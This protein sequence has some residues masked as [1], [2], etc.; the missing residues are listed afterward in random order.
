MK[1]IGKYLILL[2]AAVAASPSC[3]REIS[4]VEPGT[5]PVLSV[6]PTL[7]RGDEASLATK[8]KDDTV[9]TI[10][11]NDQVVARD[12]LR[13]NF[14]GSLDIFVKKQADAP[15]TAW[16]KE[17]H[18]NAGDS[19]V[20]IDPDKYD[21]ES[22]LDQAKQA[23]AS[24]WAE[25]GYEPDTPYDIYV[26]ANNP[27]TASGSAPA[28]LTALQALTTNTTDVYRYYLT[29]TPSQ[30]DRIYWTNCMYSEKKNFLMDGKIEGWTIDPNKAEQVFDVD[31]KRAAAKI[32][33]TVNF[34]D[35]K[36]IAMIPEPTPSNPDPVPVTDS[37]GRVVMGSVKE[38]M[39]LVGRTVGEPRIKPVNFNLNASDI[40]YDADPLPGSG[41]LLTIDGNY[42]TFKEG[43]SADNTD[44][45]F[46]VVTYTYPIDWSTDGSRTPYI[47]LSVFYTRDS[48]GDQLRSY[49]RIP[50]CDESTVTSLERNNIYIIDVEIASLGA[51]N[52]S[53][54]AKDEELRI[55]Y[56]VIPWTETNMTQE[57]TTVKISDTKFLT[58]IPT[59]YT[60]KGDDT[61]SVDL[62]WYAS[63]STD[64]N[65]IVDINTSTVQV[66]YVNYQGNTV[67][68]V[69]SVTKQI[70]NDSGNLV[71]ATNANTDGKHDIVITATAPT[72]GA[73]G[74]KVIITLTPNGII[75]V[76][77]EALASRAV[78]DIS[79]TAYLKNAT[80]VDAVPITIRHF[81]LDNIQSFTGLWSSKWNETYTTETVREY[82]F[83]PEADGWGSASS[84]SYE[85]NI[86]CSQSEYNSAYTGKSTAT[87]NDGTPSDNDGRVNYTT[88]TNGSTVQ[89]QYRNNVTQ[90]VNRYNTNGEANAALGAD[91][92]WYWGDTRTSGST[93]NY[94][95]RGNNGNSTT[96]QRY[97]WTNYHRS[98]YSQKIEYYARR[99]Y[100]D[101]Q[102]QIASTGSWV[103]WEKHTGT[104]T[105]DGI[106]FYAKVYA[107]GV[108]NPIDSGGSTY[109]TD[110]SF[111][112][113]TNPQMYVIQLTSTS[114]TYAI[115]RPVLDGNYQSQD[116]VCSPAFMIASQLGA[117]SG[118][119]YTAATAAEHCG[120]YME[121]DKDGNRYTGWRLPT[122][123]EIETIIKYQTEGAA[124]YGVT[125][126]RVL[127]GRYYWALDGNYYQAYASGTNNTFTRCV[128]DLTYEEIKRLNKEKD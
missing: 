57:A 51:S 120:T 67:N 52:E 34:S 32:L 70:R 17:Y 44:N 54:E 41:T 48:D 76:E 22:L 110:N 85:D 63:V 13:E 91:G 101:V 69:G 79:F 95:W 74:E 102:K 87:L 1:G 72:S 6:R 97:R 107:N 115:G 71:T 18:L 117:V 49:Y 116:N 123:S 40:A 14:F 126:V 65:R 58:V 127:A 124:S 119:A 23:L 26:T 64:D 27:H 109:H 93:T 45:T 2:L 86:E 103:D 15:G 114:N 5:S 80:G 66:S 9:S 28:N 37:Q 82:S 10:V 11:K 47:L 89:T 19:G 118:G 30:E 29:Y 88:G 77:S 78:K 81:P 53:F 50:V 16:F 106:G 8:A 3:M 7:F 75:N 62:Q 104:T 108:S 128:R 60:L 4:L 100:R 21:N 92:Y 84:F 12:E 105:Y 122:K 56:H 121:V 94:D 20:V 33:L 68:L 61:Q 59:E 36:T 98:Q 31:L 25:Q 55:E 24:N 73:E 111:S 83:N 38:Y 42:T 113:L 43:D 125:M 96:G 112:N 99:Y 39:Q 90:G 46:A 35:D